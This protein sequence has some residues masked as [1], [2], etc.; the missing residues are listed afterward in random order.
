MIPAHYSSWTHS[1]SP[2]SY[3]RTPP[4]Y[5]LYQFHLRFTATIAS[6]YIIVI[7]INNFYWEMNTTD[8][9][10]SV[11]IFINAEFVIVSSISHY[12]AR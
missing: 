1:F 7:A 4:S 6:V 5:F 10:V 2:I 3:H 8:K 11:G 12:S 9:S